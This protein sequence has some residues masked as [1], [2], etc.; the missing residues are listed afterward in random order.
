[1]FIQGNLP[2]N[3]NII[4]NGPNNYGGLTAYTPTG[5]TNFGIDTTR[6]SLPAGNAAFTNVLSGIL[7]NNLAIT[8]GLI[9]GGYVTT[10][11]I[12]SS[13][14]NSVWTLNTSSL[15]SASNTNYNYTSNS[16][17]ATTLNKDIVTAYNAVASNPSAANPVLADGQTF[18]TN[19]LSVATAAQA[20]QIGLQSNAEGYSSN[21]TIRLEQI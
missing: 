3:Y 4:I 18:T 5:T 17:S 13:T 12:L 7:L 1:M 9:T 21:R 6:S 10:R 2:T 14:N 11:W 20:A 16:S 19:V 15:A 8:S